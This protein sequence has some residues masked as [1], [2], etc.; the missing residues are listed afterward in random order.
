LKLNIQ[1]ANL[2]INNTHLIEL[3]RELVDNAFKFSIKSTPVIVSGEAGKDTFLITVADN[4]VGLSDEQIA[5]FGAFISQAE[6]ANTT[7]LGIGIFN[8]KG[9]LGIYHGNFTVESVR[10]NGTTVRVRI[11]LA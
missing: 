6:N 7:G 11:P 2:A 8:I 9:I 4:G 10:G 1:E 5:S 3:V